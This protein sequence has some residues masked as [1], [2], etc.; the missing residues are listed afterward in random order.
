MAAYDAGDLDTA[1]MYWRR[2]LHLEPGHVPSL[3]NLAMVLLSSQR[4]NEAAAH[5]DA[6]TSLSPLDADAFKSLGVILGDWHMN[7]VTTGMPFA[8]L[9]QPVVKVQ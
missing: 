6:L 5:M 3:N 4:Y 1:A 9:P 2:A 7:M 8:E